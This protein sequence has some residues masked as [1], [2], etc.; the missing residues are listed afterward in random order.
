MT[1][2][3]RMLRYA[4]RSHPGCIRETN[5]DRFYIPPE[6]GPLIFAVADGMGGHVA[7]EVASSIAIETLETNISVLT[8]KLS[9]CDLINIRDYLQQSILEANE[10]ILDMQLQKPELKGMGTTFT[11]AAFFNKNELLTGH[12]GDSQAHLFN[13]SG[14][15]QITEDHSVVM[16]LLKNGEIKHEEIYTHPQRNFLT[17]ALGTTTS[18]KIDFYRNDIIPGDYILLCTDGLTSMLR[19]REIQEIILHSED[20]EAAAN[21]LI[22]KANAQGGLDN[23]TFVL[24]H[25]FE[26]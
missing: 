19:P 20:L 14:H 3:K 12:V 17:R 1:R 26:R 15:L 24:I 2:G 9:K 22:N 21:E 11:V 13:K 16:E 6:N 18:L 10:N 4:V 5:E 23:I 8:E 25:Y 7:G